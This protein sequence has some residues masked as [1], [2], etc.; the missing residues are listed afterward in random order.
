MP[1]NSRCH[2]ELAHRN[3]AHA[4]HHRYVHTRVVDQ[5]G[6][7]GVSRADTTLVQSPG[8]APLT[9]THTRELSR[10]RQQGGE[11]GLRST[12]PQISNADTHSARERPR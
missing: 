1:P 9:L 7:E 11:G 2:A 5:G 3:N 10:Q 12:R 4:G 6:P 8:W